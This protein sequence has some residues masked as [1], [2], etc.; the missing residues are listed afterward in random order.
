M[1]NAMASAVGCTQTPGA[2]R[3]ACLKQVPASVIRNFTNGPESGMYFPVVDKYV[4]NF[5]W[6]GFRELKVFLADIIVL[7]FSPTHYSASA[8]GR[9]HACHS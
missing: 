7:P 6:L 8:P 1:F 9:A 5:E 2:A 3:L 4:F